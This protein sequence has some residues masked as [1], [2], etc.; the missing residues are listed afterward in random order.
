MRPDPRGA[1]LAANHVQLGGRVAFDGGGLLSD[2]M[3]SGEEE[4]GCIDW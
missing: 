1:G 3:Q 2:C 4:A